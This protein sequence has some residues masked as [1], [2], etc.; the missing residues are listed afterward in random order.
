VVA[1]VVDRG[2][3]CCG[4]AS[5]RDV[6]AVVA[7][8]GVGAVFGR[9]PALGRGEYRCRSGPV[10]QCPAGPT[11]VG[12]GLCCG[13]RGPTD[14]MVSVECWRIRPGGGRLWV[15]RRPGRA[16]ERAARWCAAPAGPMGAKSHMN[17]APRKDKQQEIT[18][19]HPGAG[20]GGHVGDPSVPSVCA[21]GSV[22]GDRGQQTGGVQPGAALD[23]AEQVV[24]RVRGVE[25]DVVAF[26]FWLCASVSLCPM[27]W[28]TSWRAS[29]L[30]PAG[31]RRMV[32][33]PG[34]AG[35]VMGSACRKWFSGGA[36]V[37]CDRRPAGSRA[38]GPGRRRGVRR[39]S[40]FTVETNGLDHEASCVVATSCQHKE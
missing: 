7:Q 10:G 28:R 26:E 27:S 3:W 39:R 38:A 22:R 8:R 5:P 17:Y 2:R 35:L 24:R 12:G 29:W 11:T 40:A 18:S 23:Q 34:N 13:A 6:P 33:F 14:V 36:E 1:V 16:Y 25:G 30:G 31:W 20:G 15:G 32:I 21:A 9:P 19:I 4:D 37:Q